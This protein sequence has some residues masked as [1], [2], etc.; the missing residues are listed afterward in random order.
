MVLIHVMNTVNNAVTTFA[1]N[2]NS[3]AVIGGRYY[4]VDSTGM[5]ELDNGFFDKGDTVVGAIEATVTTGEIDFNNAFLK[6]VESFYIAMRAKGDVTLNVYADEVLAGTYTLS[7]HDI[8]TLK[9]TR[10]LIGKGARG[11][12]WQF[13]LVS[14][15]D[16]D[17]DAYNVLVVPTARKV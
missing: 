8:D 12:Y 3:Y 6:R 14:S 1:W 5:Y 4:G 7:P 2:F 17:F 10:S 13:E 9:Q 15:S 16:F 11:R